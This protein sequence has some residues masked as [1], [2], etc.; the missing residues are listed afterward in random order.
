[1]KFLVDANLGR[2]FANLLKHAGYDVIFAKDMMPLFRDEEI[3]AKAEKE[4]RTVITNDKDFGELIFRMGRS[5]SGVILL[6]TSKTN[7]NERFE[8]VRE[9]LDKAEG[10]FIVVKEGQIRIRDLK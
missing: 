1:M 6:R 9:V 8:L 5:A 7:F 3:L 2:K 4:K 10:K